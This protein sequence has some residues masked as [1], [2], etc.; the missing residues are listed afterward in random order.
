VPR[1][2]TV[3]LDAVGRV[4]EASALLAQ[5]RPHGARPRGPPHPHLTPRLIEIDWV[6]DL[7]DRAD[8]Q[9]AWL[10]GAGFAA[11]LVWTYRD[12]AVIRATR[13]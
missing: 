5:D 10:E 13:R 6:D 7:P 2:G 1:P 4:A 12:L 3:A 9:L 8:D 11:E